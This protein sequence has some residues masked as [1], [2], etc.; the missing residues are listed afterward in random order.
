MFGRGE[1]LRKYEQA[2]SAH[3]SA[4]RAVRSRTPINRRA[5]LCEAG[6]ENAYESKTKGGACVLDASHWPA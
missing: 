3:L 4:R 2:A 5:P 6:Q 1:D